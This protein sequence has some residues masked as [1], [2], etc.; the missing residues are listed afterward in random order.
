MESIALY[1]SEMMIDE[2]KLASIRARV[3]TLTEV[4]RENL[5]SQLEAEGIPWSAVAVD[6]IDDGSLPLADHDR[7]PRLRLTPSQSHLW[8]LHQLYPRLT[9]YHI[10]FAWQLRGTLDTAALSSAL[11]ELVAQQPS[12]R[13]VFIPDEAGRPYQ[14]VLPA[15]AVSVETVNVGATSHLACMATAGVLLETPFDLKKGPL[16]RLQLQRFSQDVHSLVF[17]FHHLIADGWS[18]GVLLRQ[19]ADLYSAHADVLGTSHDGASDQR[20]LR[21]AKQPQETDRIVYST[22]LADQAWLD[23]TEHAEQ[24]D[25]WKQQLAG[26]APLELP[27]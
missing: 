7:P 1:A 14:E 15:E 10:A 27:T 18:R 6:R 11:T 16:F 26:L 19:L 21:S 23:T 24:L 4:Q 17:V 13:T 12:L 22:Y 9:A 8:V 20:R 3:A 2:A 25:Y 5:R